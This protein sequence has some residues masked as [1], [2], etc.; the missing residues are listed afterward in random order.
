MGRRLFVGDLHGCRQELEDL[1]TQFAFNPNDD[2]L[3]SV[4]DIVGKGPDVVGTLALLQSLNARVVLGNHDLR[5]LE[6]ADKKESD[7]DE[8]Q[9]KYLHSLGNQIEPWLT[10]MRG[11]PLWIDLPDVLVVHAGIE[12]GKKNLDDMHPYVLTHIRT[13]DGEGKHLNR[14]DDP[15]WF[16]CVTWPKTIVFG[17]WA[18]RGQV[19]E[20]GFKGLDTGCVYGRKL[21]GWCPET[22]SWHQVSARATYQTISKPRPGF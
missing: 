11:W 5:L 17:H 8:N 4:G 22:N 19:N 13:W 7:R 18:K 12:P 2:Q 21:S 10:Y 15:A 3:F 16:D 1:L 9:I 20:M 6:G 14:P